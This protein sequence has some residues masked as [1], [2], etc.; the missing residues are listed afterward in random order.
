MGIF[1][2]QII[3][4]KNHPEGEWCDR[5]TEDEDVVAIRATIVWSRFHEHIVLY[6]QLQQDQPKQASTFIPW[7]LNNTKY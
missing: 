3:T 4:Y 6:E 7:Y 1:T 2:K 5:R